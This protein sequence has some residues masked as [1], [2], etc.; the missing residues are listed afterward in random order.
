MQ[1][2][3]AQ[4]HQLPIIVR[5]LLAGHNT[6][7]QGCEDCQMSSENTRQIDGDVALPGLVDGGACIQDAIS[8]TS[9]TVMG[10]ED[11][12]SVQSEPPLPKIRHAC[13]VADQEASFP[14]GCIATRASV[15]EDI[16]NVMLLNGGYWARCCKFR[17]SV[18]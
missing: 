12:A 6:K 8:D 14:R 11:I 4:G 16:Q 3:A 7:A 9:K 2:N 1:H 17:D 10:C 5:E 13:N 15:L 18:V